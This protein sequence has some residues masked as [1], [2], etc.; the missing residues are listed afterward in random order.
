M[1][2]ISEQVIKSE[3]KCLVG[4]HL[5]M[6]ILI[7]VNWITSPATDNINPDRIDGQKERDF[8]LVCV[9]MCERERKREREKEREIQ[10]INLIIEYQPY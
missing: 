7:N 1:T 9:C 8:V 2:C 10:L 5:K 3:V 4:K 6:S